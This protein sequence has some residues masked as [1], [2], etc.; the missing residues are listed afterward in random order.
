MTATAT[1]RTATEMA[2]LRAASE[3]ATGSVSAHYRRL[4]ASTLATLNWL[5]LGGLS[6][7]SNAAMAPDEAG[8]ATEVLR[9]ADG[10]NDAVRYGGD[11]V[12]HEGVYSTLRWYADGAE[13]PIQ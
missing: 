12:W 10:E 3:R 1:L 8:V 5:E 13:A 9:A 7:S 2:G 4:A 6:P 11:R